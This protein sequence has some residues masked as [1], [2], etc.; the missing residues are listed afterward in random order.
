MR[1]R[2]ATE[3]TMYKQGDELKLCTRPEWGIGRITKVEQ[4]TRDGERDQRI[5]V[6]FPNVGVKTILAGAAELEHLNQSNE[7]EHTFLARENAHETGWLGEIAKAQPEEAMIALPP[8]TTDPFASVR[9]R[10]KTL[11]KLYRFTPDGGSLIDWAIAQTGMDDPLSRFNRH[12]LEE[13]FERWACDRD[14]QARQLFIEAR[15][16]GESLDDLV[17]LGTK[18]L[19]RA[20][21][22]KSGRA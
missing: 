2:T 20:L 1:T 19:S 8:E 10:F 21:K 6:K 18:Q 12:E 22:E 17:A 3:S 4:V 5:W 14:D 9:T 13:F 11:A 7:E 16:N 15:R